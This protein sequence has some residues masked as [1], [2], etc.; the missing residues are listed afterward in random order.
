V[1][2]SGR[3]G[4]GSHGFTL[5]EGSTG[6]PRLARTKRMGLA[7]YSRL[8]MRYVREFDQKW[9]RAGAPADEPL[10]G[11]ADIQSLADLDNSFEIVKSMKPAP[12]GKD[13][14]LQ[15]A[16]ISLAPVAPQLRRKHESPHRVSG[17]NE[18][19]TRLRC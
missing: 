13:T 19:R 10:V 14:L 2:I 5:L 8:A 15:L 1:Q 4:L 6:K 3:G 16:V 7:E 11:S 9:L 18:S 17:C 12:F